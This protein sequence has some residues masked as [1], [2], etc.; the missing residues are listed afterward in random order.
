MTRAER[1]DQDLLGLRAMPRAITAA[2]PSDSRRRPVHSAR[3][4]DTG[5]IHYAWHPLVGKRVPII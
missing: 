2:R 4:S 1:R 5:E 3:V